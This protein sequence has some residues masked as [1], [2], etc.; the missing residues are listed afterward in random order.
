MHD[1]LPSCFNA[2]AERGADGAAEPDTQKP[3]QNLTTCLYHT[4]HL[5]SVAVT[6]CRTTLGHSFTISLSNISTT[7]HHSTPLLFWRKRKGS[8]SLSLFNHTN[9][10]GG[11][12]GGAKTS[13]SLSLFNQNTRSS[14]STHLFWDLTRAHYPPNSAEPDRGFYIALK[15]L[16]D[17]VLLLGDRIGD[18]LAVTVAKPISTLPCLVARREHVFGTR[19]CTARAALTGGRTHEIAISWGSELCVR[20][21]DRVVVHVRELAWKFRGNQEIELEGVKVGVYWDVFDWFFGGCENGHAVFM[22]RADGS[23]V[24]SVVWPPSGLGVKGREKR[25]LKTGSAS[26]GSSSGSGSSSSCSSSS[27]LEWVGVEEEVNRGFSLL[28][29]AWKN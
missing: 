16:D 25:L 22:F 9:S 5:G 26:G 28:L 4:H 12:G 8:K 24:G 10:G 15:Y 19:L 20:I 6:W 27:V 14:K 11:G 23:D 29:Y 13:K 17:I 2:G 18:A 21:D 1:A 7:L 3:I